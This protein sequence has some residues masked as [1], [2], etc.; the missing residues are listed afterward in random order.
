MTIL[1]QISSQFVYQIFLTYRLLF[2]L[3]FSGNRAL[4]VRSTTETRKLTQLEIIGGFSPVSW[5]RLQTYKFTYTSHPDPKQQFV[6]HTKSCSVRESN[7]LPVARQPVA[8]PPH[9]PCNFSNDQSTNSHTVSAVSGQLAAVQRVA[10]SIPTRSNYFCEPQIVVSELARS[11]EWNSNR[12]ILYYMGLITQMVKCG[13]ILYIGITCRVFAF[14]E[15][16]SSNNFSRLGRCE[17]E[18]QTLTN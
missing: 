18:C 1:F 4:A 11:L 16:N 5:V 10:G 13:C 3:S 9:Q 6:D 17:I 14:E 12:L 2:V 8:Q 15:I 7:P